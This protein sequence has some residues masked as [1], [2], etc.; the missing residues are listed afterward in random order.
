MGREP[1]NPWWRSGPSA[2]RVHMCVSW[3]A[4][5]ATMLPYVLRAAHGAPGSPTTAS[6]IGHVHGTA[7]HTALRDHRPTVCG[8]L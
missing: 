5:M 7:K 8:L 4:V 1:T 2:T 3:F 6:A